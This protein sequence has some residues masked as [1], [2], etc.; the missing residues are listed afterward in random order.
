MR[1]P[2]HTR[3][4]FLLLAAAL[5]WSLGGVL[6]K[7]VNW[8]P[9]AVGGG[10]G[11]IAAIFLMLV[12]GRSLKFQWGLLPIATAVAYAGCTVLFAAATKL[13][14]AANA[15]LLQYTAPVYVALLG[16]WLL[17]EKPR[18]ADWVTMAFVFTGMAIFLF[19]GLRF[20]SLPGILLAIASGVSF[21]FMIVLLRMQRDGSPLSSIVLGNL[22]GFFIGLP[23]M[24]GAPF[25]DGGSLAA[26]VILGVVQLGFAYILYARAIRHV[27]ALEGVLIPVIE[28]ILNPLWVMLVIGEVPSSLALVGGGIVLGAVTWRAVD[29]ILRPPREVLNP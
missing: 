28:P 1:D 23:S 14:T 24:L 15:I 9:L 27:T 29:S 8:P 2:A 6:L 3:S 25:P 5:C 20:N 21:A 16:A 4:V 12:L 17:K 26:L 10:R 22:L 11:L 18:R 7:S 13:T 19:D